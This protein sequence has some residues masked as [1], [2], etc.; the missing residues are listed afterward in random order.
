MKAT[1]S[2]LLDA[3]T[4]PALLDRGRPVSFHALADESCRIAQGLHALGVRAG[5]RVAL[6][7]PNLPAWLAVFF[8]CARLGAIAVAVNT[9]FRGGELAD[10]LQRSRSRVLIF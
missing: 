1:L 4:A 8:A 7:L 3:G 6:W 5:D 2:S 10:I 9:R